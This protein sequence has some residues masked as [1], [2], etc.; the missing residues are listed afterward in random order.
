MQPRARRFPCN[1][2]EALKAD[3]GGE[4]ASVF[5]MRQM[6]TRSVEDA[7]G[8]GLRPGLA[9]NAIA[10]ERSPLAARSED[11]VL[12]PII[13]E[14][15]LPESRGGNVGQSRGGQSASGGAKSGHLFPLF[16]ARRSDIGST[17]WDF[18]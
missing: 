6:G 8:K 1:F 14:S 15:M 9:E 10:K 13:A 2:G 12:L 4:G 18:V 11:P 17:P 16:K 5:A 7:G 3:Y